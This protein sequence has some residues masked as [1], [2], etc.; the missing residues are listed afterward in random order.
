MVFL[1]NLADSLCL[2]PIFVPYLWAWVVSIESLNSQE[3][4]VSTIEK[5]RS[6]NLV[7]TRPIGDR[8]QKSRSR[9][10]FTKCVNFFSLL[11]K[12]WLILSFFSIEISQ[13]VEIF[14]PEVPQKI[15]IKARYLYK[16]QK[17]LTILMKI[18]CRL[19]LIQK[20]QF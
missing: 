16:S 11:I 5:S 9:S 17:V 4:L 20:S 15:S 10:R 12:S 6:R 7:L 19:I 3:K 18:L 1:E 2:W 8:S 13:F 14:E